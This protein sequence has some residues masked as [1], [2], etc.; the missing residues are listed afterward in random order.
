EDGFFRVLH[1]LALVGFRTAVSSDLGRNLADDLLV[2][3]GDDDFR[4]LRAG[5]RDALR[6][7]VG[8][9]VAEAQRQRE[10]AALHGGA[11]TDAVDLKAALETGLHALHDVVDLRTGH[12]PLRTSVLRLVARLD[13]DGAVL[14]LH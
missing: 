2:D 11:V 1:A 14:D 12:A 4:R 3:T 9:I 13:N 8:D 6:R 5:N 7:H 10:I